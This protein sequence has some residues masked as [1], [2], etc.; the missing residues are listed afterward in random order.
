MSC[1]VRVLRQQGDRT[2]AVRRVE[3]AGAGGAFVEQQPTER[4]LG[5][6]RAG[7][8][9]APSRRLDLTRP[10]DRKPEDGKVRHVDVAR[11]HTVHCP[12]PTRLEQPASGGVVRGAARGHRVDQRLNLRVRGRATGG[13]LLGEP[14]ELG[15][16]QQREVGT[17]AELVA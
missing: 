17:Q 8:D 16:R 12:D 4:A 7:D 13:V 3:G 10:A 5:S 1:A 9:L 14:L 2:P 15:R 6:E 11:V